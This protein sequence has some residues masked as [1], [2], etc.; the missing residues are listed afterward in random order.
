MY[1]LEYLREQVS[2]DEQFM[3]Q[4]S[5]LIKT[6]TFA[7]GEKIIESGHRSNKVYFIEKGIVRL[8]YYKDG[9]EITHLF[10]SEQSVY[11]SVE[12]VFYKQCS[13]FTAETLE[14]TTV[15]YMEYSDIEAILNQSHELEAF[16]RMLLI[17]TLKNIS[18]KLS[19]IVFQSAQD[20]YTTLLEKHPDIFQR[21]QLG[22][23]ASYIGITQQTLSVL[24]GKR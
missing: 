21:A 9:K 7:K 13:Q 6:K 12:S 4:F 19:D 8:Y 10:F 2:L 17:D 20:R 3:A 11:L 15:Q 5:H 24:R 18:D 16:V 1:F 23:I 14:P 22:H